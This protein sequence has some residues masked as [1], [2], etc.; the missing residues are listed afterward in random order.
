M[1]AHQYPYP[2]Y[3]KMHAYSHHPFI[4]REEAGTQLAGRLTR[5]RNASDVIVLAIPKGGVRVGARIAEILGKPFDVLLVGKISVPSCHDA[6]LGAITSGGVRM[7]NGELIDRLHLSPED[8]R[9]AILKK[10]LQLARRERRYRGD[11]P[12]LELADHT[13]ILADDGSTP[14]AA[15]R[16]GI[17]LLHRQHVE[18][19]VVAIPAT[20]E[21]AACDLRLETDDVVTLT[22]PHDPSPAGDWFSIFPPTYDSDIRELVTKFHYGRN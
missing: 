4:S 15:I 3:L 10:S 18:R 6:A 9:A 21:H 17:R 13:V 16:N 8:V 14:C 1:R 7:L 11:Q 19:I 20:C 2:R 22:E 12:S 5:Y